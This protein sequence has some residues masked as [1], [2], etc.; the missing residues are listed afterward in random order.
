MLPLL[1]SDFEN[2]LTSK[3]AG[4]A[5]MLQWGWKFILVILRPQVVEVRG[6]G[7]NT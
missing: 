7:G 1:M 6:N 5:L 4:D 3:E 2:V